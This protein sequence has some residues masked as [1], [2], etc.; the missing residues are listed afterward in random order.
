M[1]GSIQ[2]TISWVPSFSLTRLVN[3]S[4]SSLKVENFLKECVLLLWLLLIRVG[5]ILVSQTF[6]CHSFLLKVFFILLE[7]K[8]FSEQPAYLCSE[9]CEAEL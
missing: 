3:V 8:R 6:Y 4:V 2:K 9:V 5:D 1:M 7:L